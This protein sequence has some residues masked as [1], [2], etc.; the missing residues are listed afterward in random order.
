MPL[1]FT[2]Q[3]IEAPLLNSVPSNIIP[4]IHPPATINDYFTD[5]RTDLTNT[6]LSNQVTGIIQKFPPPLP[7][8]PPQSPQS[9]DELDDD[10][11]GG[12]MVPF[13]YPPPPI[14]N[15][16]TLPYSLASFKSRLEQV[17]STMVRIFVQAPPLPFPPPNYMAYPLSANKS[18]LIPADVFQSFISASEELPRTDM[19]VA[20]AA[21]SLFDMREQANDEGFNIE[22]FERTR[23]YNNPRSEQ[24]YDDENESEESDEEDADGYD[25]DGEQLEYLNRIDTT[26]Y[27]DPFENDNRRDV[28]QINMRSPAYETVSK[29][30]SKLKDANYHEKTKSNRENEY[31][32]AQGM[33]RSF[34]ESL[35]PSDIID[36]PG[37]DITL[38]SGSNRERRRSELVKSMNTVEEFNEEN[39]D[40]IYRMK[41]NQLLN[42]LHN[43]RN[44]KIT[45]T[46]VETEDEEL[47]QFRQL[48]EIE[49]DEQLIQL[50][51]SE[52]YELLKTSLVFYEDSNKAY[53]N[54]NLVLI[55]K[56]EK[57]KN[58]FVYQRDLFTE[59]L[60]RKQDIFDIKSKESQKL[61]NGISNRNY[62][63][64][65]KNIIK[66]S[67]INEQEQ[68]LKPVEIPDHDL[69]TLAT[70]TSHVLVHD[71]MP[72][73]TPEEFSIITGDI[74][75]KSKLSNNAKDNKP[76]TNMKHHIFQNSLYDRMTS[77]S[78][79]NASD[80]NISSGAA[81]GS[82][83]T[84]AGPKRRG[85]R[86]AQ[87]LQQAGGASGNTGN[88]SS[89]NSDTRDGLGVK[90]SEAA[91]ISK[92]TKHFVGP[93]SAMP[94]EL[95]NDLDM[96]GIQ[97]RWPVSK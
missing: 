27:L 68:H 93:Q 74:P 41:K 31:E 78:D 8:F 20:S 25:E 13:I 30:L 88:G 77:G 48:A 16:D 65:I 7:P 14:I 54:L 45:F 53:K 2:R 84:T 26:D 50:K 44:S 12:I 70:D 33:T 17:K 89:K 58:F 4:I 47:D 66:S 28:F 72:L 29:K 18:T 46:S 43:L 73:I 97:T 56:L 95:T 10:E 94:D 71:F 1:P 64:E 35:S 86:S 32:F 87:S 91:L 82:G 60:E 5:V 19:V 81:S 3:Q 83:S 61:F 42:R 55:N 79:T 22:D 85:R 76:A 39:R 96:M 40:E 23:R 9:D 6:K 75:R 57:L 24:S 59:Y 34:L 63:Q 11:R 49:R 90:Y 37:K 92:I 38:Q 69:T 21:G 52:N 36:N 80:A 15:P 51:L 62:S 67:I